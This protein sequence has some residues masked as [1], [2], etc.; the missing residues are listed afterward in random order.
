MFWL[1]CPDLKETKGVV[2]EMKI[3]QRLMQLR[4]DSVYEGSGKVVEAVNYINANSDLTAYGWQA[5]AGLPVGAVGVSMRFESM[6]SLLSSQTALVEDAGYMEIAQSAQEMLA[7]PAQDWIM[8]VIAASDDMPADPSDFLANTVARAQLDNVGA[9][10]DWSQRWVAMVN[11][12]AGTPAAGLMSPHG[13]G[14]VSF[15]QLLYYDSLTQYEERQTPEVWSM[16]GGSSLMREGFAIFDEG[17]N[18]S[19]LMRRIA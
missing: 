14:G 1:G 11:S 19:A 9:A 7:E 5:V 8:D 15:A 10:I 4:P 17:S 13:E 3:F 6:D 18:T 12:I 2:G 16:V